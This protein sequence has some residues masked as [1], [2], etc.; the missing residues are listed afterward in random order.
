[1]DGGGRL[2]QPLKRSGQS[3]T[4]R[5][6]APVDQPDYARA[7]AGQDPL[8]PGFIG[9]RRIRRLA[10]R[11]AQLCSDPNRVSDGS[12]RASPPNFA[13]RC[14]VRGSVGIA[15]RRALSTGQEFIDQIEKFSKV[16]KAT[17]IANG[18]SAKAAMKSS[19]R[20]T[21]MV[22]IITTS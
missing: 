8:N 17:Q 20:N 7:D 21:M 1:M 13:R 14:C 22:P 16:A 4:K 5:F 3:A 12:F 6:G 2:E 11:L 19:R 9:N 15:L 18:I 10:A